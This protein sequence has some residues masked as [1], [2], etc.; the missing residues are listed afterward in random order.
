MTNII[1]VKF[2]EVNLTI[3]GLPGVIVMECEAEVFYT[4]CDDWTVKA[5]TVCLGDTP[6]PKDLAYAISHALE[7]IKHHSETIIDAIIKDMGE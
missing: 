6:A 4:D 7:S 1:T 5:H 3:A 2:E